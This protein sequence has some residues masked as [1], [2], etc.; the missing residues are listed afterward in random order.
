MVCKRRDVEARGPGLGRKKGR[1]EVRVRGSVN[2][3]DQWG[4]LWYLTSPDGPGSGVAGPRSS[5]T[6][7]WDL[8]WVKQTPLHFLEPLQKLEFVYLQQ[9]ELAV[10]AAE[11]SATGAECSSSNSRPSSIDLF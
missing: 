9:Q 11:M 5:D 1:G 3:R 10:H 7:L 2:T 6:V 8:V 4:S